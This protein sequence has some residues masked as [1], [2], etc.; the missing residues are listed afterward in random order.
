MQLNSAF[1]L[2]CRTGVEFSRAMPVAGE[3][4]E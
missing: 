1:V 3:H 2:N 4:Q